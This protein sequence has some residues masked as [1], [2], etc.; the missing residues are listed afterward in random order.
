MKDFGQWHSEN[1]LGKPDSR[2]P[3]LWS[4]MTRLTATLD[5][6]AGPEW[7]ALIGAESKH[8]GCCVVSRSRC[9]G[10]TVMLFNF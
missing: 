3:R 4:L 8:T 10:V 1:H 6:Q 5:C 7:L 9:K 2:I